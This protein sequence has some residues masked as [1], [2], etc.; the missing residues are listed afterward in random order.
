MLGKAR[1]PEIRPA[2]AGFGDELTDWMFET[3]FPARAD[4]SAFAVRASERWPHGSGILWVWA[5]RWLGPSRRLNAPDAIVAYFQRAD[6]EPFLVTPREVMA[7]ASD[8]EETPPTELT[9]PI[10]PNPSRVLAQGELRA[11]LAKKDS[12]T[13]GAAA[14]SLLLV[15]AVN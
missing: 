2:L 1:G 13:R 12:A 14:L 7:L 10:D 9:G 11:M 3:V 6:A 8:C 4:E 15:A 5:L